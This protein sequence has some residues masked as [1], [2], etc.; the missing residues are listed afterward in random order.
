M[1]RQR[2]TRSQRA[3]YQGTCKACSELFLTRH[4]YAL[5]CCVNCKV[6][7][8][9]Y[10]KQGR[11]VPPRLPQ[12][13]RLPEAHQL[14]LAVTPTVVTPTKALPPASAGMETRI[15]NGTAI[16]RRADG[17]I[18]ATAMAKAG[19]KHLPHY[20]VNVRTVEYLQALSGSVGIP[21]DLLVE[22]TMTGPNEQRGTWVHPR[23]AVDLARW[24]SPAFAVWMDGWF[25]E[26]L[27]QKP[28]R[29]SA[30]QLSNKELC[31]LWLTAIEL[32]LQGALAK[33]LANARSSL[34]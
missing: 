29:P 23:L 16:Q 26:S 4:P 13:Q 25:L 17:F 19:G 22:T 31:G 14:P 1:N 24:I 28:E 33:A 15:W 3:V 20:M 7:F 12:A 9:Y 27:E 34:T 30:A 21:T 8:H 5:F 2:S 32:D 11:P 6:R 10:A 18:N